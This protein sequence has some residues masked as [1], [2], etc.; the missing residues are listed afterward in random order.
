MSWSVLD[1][2]ALDQ[3]T[4]HGRSA[5]SSTVTPENAGE[6]LW[7]RAE[8]QTLRRLPSTG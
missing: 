3:P 1:D 5:L 2:P 4:G 6:S 8:R 7:L